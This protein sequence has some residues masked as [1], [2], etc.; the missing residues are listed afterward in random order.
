MCF[1]CKCAN[2]FLFFL[3]FGYHWC[4]H[5]VPCSQLGW[6]V[7]PLAGWW[8][9]RWSLVFW[10]RG[11]WAK[12]WRRWTGRGSPWTLGNPRDLQS[13]PRCRSREGRGTPRRTR[14]RP[15]LPL[16]PCRLGSRGAIGPHPLR[17]CCYYCYCCYHPVT[18]SMIL[19]R[20]TGLTGGGGAA[21]YP[22]RWNEATVHRRLRSQILEM[23]K[24]S[25]SSPCIL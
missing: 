21:A 13:P 11:P 8:A 2:F 12:G 20:M 9:S 7:A 15:S 16:A 23:E 18:Y 17:H 6:A 10:T 22:L 25:I 19:R 1:P 5:A 4:F 14:F 24:Y 3:K